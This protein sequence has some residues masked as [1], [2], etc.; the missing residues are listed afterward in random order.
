MLIYYLGE[1]GDQVNLGNG[2]QEFQLKIETSNPNSTKM[3]ILRFAS[4]VEITSPTSPPRPWGCNSLS[5][6]SSRCRANE[7]AMAC[8]VTNED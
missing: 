7:A 1:D 3:L 2:I 5:F 8:A 6:L 4:L